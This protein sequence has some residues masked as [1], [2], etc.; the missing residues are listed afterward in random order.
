MRIYGYC[1]FANVTMLAL[2]AFFLTGE[3]LAAILDF[4]LT[5]KYATFFSLES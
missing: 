4:K 3:E 2:L 5:V 1:V